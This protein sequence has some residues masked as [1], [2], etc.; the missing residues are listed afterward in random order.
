MISLSNAYL[1]VSILD[2]LRDQARLGS[3]YC[4]GGYIYQITDRQLGV[5]ASGP[6]FPA[7]EPPPVFDGQGLPEAF[8]IPLGGDPQAPVDGSTVLVL[9]VGLVRM[10]VPTPASRLFPVLEFCTWKVSQAPGVVTMSTLQE[11]D[12]WALELTREVALDSRTLRSLTRVKNVGE[13]EIPLRWFPHPFFPWYPT[14]GECCKFNFPVSF[15]ANPGYELAPSGFVQMKLDHPWTRAGHFQIM[16]FAQADKL[17][18]LQKHPKIGLVAA[19]C[20]YAPDFLPIWGNCNTFSFEP[21]YDSK[22]ARGEEAEWS[23][24]YDF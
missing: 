5:L 17:C 14:T 4:T 21:Y 24:T 8:T 23:I 6:G 10:L 20:S 2:P 1:D 16:Q 9:G 15:G 7:E 13:G 3:R 11:L 18:V 19:K 12:G 22:V